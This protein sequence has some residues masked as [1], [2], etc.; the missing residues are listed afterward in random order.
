MFIRVNMRLCLWLAIFK[1][2]S[3]NNK[4]QKRGEIMKKFDVSKFKYANIDDVVSG[5]ENKIRYTNKIKPATIA[6]ADINYEAALAIYDYY[7]METGYSGKSTRTSTV[8]SILKIMKSHTRD[9]LIACVDRYLRDVQNSKYAYAPHNFFGR[10][11][12]DK[13]YYRNYLNEE[14]TT[15]VDNGE[16]TIKEVNV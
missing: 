10:F 13:A 4:T 12:V 15:P 9:E 7:V 6:Q 14:E 3:Y 1:E 8:Q 2:S 11:D 5:G 16:I